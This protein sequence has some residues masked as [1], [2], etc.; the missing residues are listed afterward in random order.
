[1]VF[2]W[3]Q[4]ASPGPQGVFTFH[5]RNLCNQQVRCS[6]HP[7]SS[8]FCILWWAEATF[9][10]FPTDLE[11]NG[12]SAFEHCINLAFVILPQKMDEVYRPSF[13]NFYNM[14][15]ICQ[16]GFDEREGITRRYRH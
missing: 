9:I 5:F 2:Q 1:M 8:S 10:D 3:A 14:N 12:W 11:R 4:T 16:A 15:E 7:V 13:D 6:N